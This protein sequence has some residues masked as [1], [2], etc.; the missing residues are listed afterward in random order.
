MSKLGYLVIL[1]FAACLVGSAYAAE[2]SFTYV[3]SSGNTIGMAYALTTE[4]ELAVGVAAVSSGTISYDTEDTGEAEVNTDVT[5]DDGSATV[6]SAASDADGDSAATVTVVA[7]A[8]SATISQT[9][10][11]DT[12]DEGAIAGQETEAVDAEFVVASS[13]ATADDGTTASSELVVVDSDYVA[14]EQGAVADADSA[15]AGQEF[16]VAD[17]EFL[18]AETEAEQPDGTWAETELEAED[19]TTVI[20]VEQSAYGSGITFEAEAGQ[21]IAGLVGEDVEAE[22]AAEDADGNYVEVTAVAEN[23]L[24]FNADQ[25]AAADTGTGAVGGQT[26]TIIGTGFIGAFSDAEAADGTWA[27]ADAY[28]DA[29]G[30]SA[31]QVD[32]TVGATGVSIAEQEGIIVTPGEGSAETSAGNGMDTTLALATVNDGVIT[33]EQV[34]G[35][36]PIGFPSFGGAGSVQETEVTGDS[37]V[38][39]TS[40][41]NGW[42]TTAYTVAG[43]V[44]GGTAAAAQIAGANFFGAAAGQIVEVSGDG[45]AT[46]GVVAA[47]G[48]YAYTL[49]EADDTLGTGSIEAAQ[50]AL[51]SN[52][53]VIAAQI[54]YVDTPTGSGILV[55]GSQNGD[56][57]SNHA[58][59]TAYEE[60]SDLFGIQGA[61]TGLIED[62]D[63]VAAQAVIVGVP[64][65]FGGEGAVDYGYTYTEAGN[66]LTGIGEAWAAVGTEANDQKFGAIS[67]AYA[68]DIKVA[69]EFE[70]NDQNFPGQTGTV[71]QTAES[72]SFL[73]GYHSATHTGD[74][75]SIG[76]GLAIPFGLN[77]ALV[78]TII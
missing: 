77:G 14:V 8:E 52:D 78:A 72:Y 31:I 56:F 58:T 36:L 13:T 19:V 40:A 41:T 29:D 5:V 49:A 67:V 65:V 50:G 76:F 26:V 20:P 57:P 6:F 62:N 39:Y 44:N 3:D 74:T 11:A 28:A 59:V 60:G 32:Q 7:D 68:G 25:G 10:E 35:A 45:F 1:M 4:G 43:E 38:I 73:T 9:A 47:D 15:A 23:A 71:S 69:G 42:G 51:A 75:A 16:V 22:T 30:V 55:A 12:N 48:D 33:F 27:Q 63:A 37:G 21:T 18:A 53:D 34:S 24:N 66:G 54:A 2:D 70:I 46:T 61:A 64:I 17:A